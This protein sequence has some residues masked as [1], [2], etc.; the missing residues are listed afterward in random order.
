MKLFNSI[1][2]FL[3]AI[4]AIFFNTSLVFS[5]RSSDLNGDG[6]VDEKDKLIL[7]RSLGANKQDSDWNDKCDL[8]ENG[9]IDFKDLDILNSNFGKNIEIKFRND[10]DGSSSADESKRVTLNGIPIQYRIVSRTSMKSIELFTSEKFDKDY[11][12][13]EIQLDKDGGVKDLRIA[14]G[15][16]SKVL[17][18]YFSS[19]LKKWKFEIISKKTNLEKVIIYYRIDL[20]NI[21]PS[22]FD[23][24][25]FQ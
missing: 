8:D 11:F 10:N 6:V 20:S 9:S 25:D 16:G 24:G 18:L 14:K 17:D 19:E 3:L 23:K 2:I 22:A 12:A 15:S 21:I 4:T 5:E 13:V 7:E 1:F